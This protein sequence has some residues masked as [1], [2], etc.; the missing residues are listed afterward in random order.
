MSFAAAAEELAAVAAI[1]LGWRPDDFWRATPAEL[2]SIL[3]V[4][5]AR[6]PEGAPAMDAATL[7]RLKEICPDE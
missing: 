5:S 7:A 4:W 2:L 1:C 6:E 3:R